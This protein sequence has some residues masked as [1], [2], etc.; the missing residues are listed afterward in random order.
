MPSVR[1]ILMKTWLRIKD[2]FTIAFPLLLVAV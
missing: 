2:F 1:N